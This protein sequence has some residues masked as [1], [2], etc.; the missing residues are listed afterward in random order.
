[1]DYNNAESAAERIETLRQEVG[2]AEHV[3]AEGRTLLKTYPSSEQRFLDYL[4][5]MEARHLRET[6]S[7]GPLDLTQPVRAGAAHGT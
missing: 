3:M 5:I 1:M 4:R 2:V 7:I 6:S